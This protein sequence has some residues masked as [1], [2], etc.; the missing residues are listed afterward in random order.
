MAVIEA[1]S[2]RIRGKYLKLLIRGS[3][4]ILK[5]FSNFFMIFST[6]WSLS[7]VLLK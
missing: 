5:T 4:T 3:V 2:E 1:K 7:I 6:V